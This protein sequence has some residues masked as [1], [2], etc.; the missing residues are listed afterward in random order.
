MFTFSTDIAA[1][2]KY[3]IPFEFELQQF[4]NI[5]VTIYDLF[6]LSKK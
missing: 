4:S 1:L 5:L 2:E 3:F 6:Y